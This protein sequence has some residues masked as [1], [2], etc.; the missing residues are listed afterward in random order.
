MDRT[1]WVSVANTRKKI[2]PDGEKTNP[3]ASV[4]QLR[5]QPNPQGLEAL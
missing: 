3:K 4:P 2:S 5:D 1:N